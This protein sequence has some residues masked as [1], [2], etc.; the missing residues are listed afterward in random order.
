MSGSFGAGK[1]RVGCE[2]GYMMNLKYPGNRGLVVRDTYTD[3]WSSTIDQTLLEE[4]IPESHIASHNQTKH[5]IKHFTGHRGPDN[6]PI[7]SEIQYHGLDSGQDSDL[8]TKIGGQQYGWIFVDEGIELSKGAWVQLLGRLRFSGRNIRGKRYEVPFR[9]IYTAT[10]PAS[11]SHWMYQWFFEQEKGTWFKMTA[12]ELA[13]YVDNIPNDYVETMAESY[14]GMYYDR[15]VMGEWVASLGLVYNEFDSHVHVKRPEDVPWEGWSV[16]D[17]ID[18]GESTTAVM[19]P[20]DDWKIYRCIDFGYRD[21]FV[22]QWWARDPENDIHVLF[23][24]IYKSE[25]LIEDLAQEIK[26]HS[27]GFRVEQTWADPASAEDRATLERHGVNTEGAKKDV[28]AGIQEVKAKLNT[29]GDGARLFFIDGA[30]A[31][32]P[33]SNLDDNN[34]PI[35]TVEEITE[36]QW[37]DDKDEP[38]K[39]DDHGMD[40]MRYYVH[41]VSQGSPLSRDDMEELEN[42]FNGGF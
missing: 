2:K 20:P 34:N 36:Y 8:P 40:T 18:H 23:R 16:T 30:L 6:E 42:V 7:L 27:E 17:R 15:Y 35:S 1:S 38:E 39:A 3:V 28:S 37:K 26:R 13:K 5:K 4:V 19:S 22:C 33:D 32:A 11:K 21:P 9:Q 10:N 41:T 29:E 24:E 31:H 12:H 14:T 25:E